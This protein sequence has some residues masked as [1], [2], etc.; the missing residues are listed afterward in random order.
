LKHKPLK[1]RNHF[2][3]HPKRYF[4]KQYL[5][6]YSYFFYQVKSKE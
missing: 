2:E 6:Q 5:K 4:L 3:V 1:M